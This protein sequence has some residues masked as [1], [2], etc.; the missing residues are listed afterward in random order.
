MSSVLSSRT[1]RNMALQ[2]EVWPSST[3]A[4]EEWSLPM[5]MRKVISLIGALVIAIYSCGSAIAAEEI[6]VPVPPLLERPQV[7]PSSPE[8]QTFAVCGVGIKCECDN[9]VSIAQARE[10]QSC[11]VTSSTG[12]CTFQSREDDVGVCCVCRP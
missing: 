10:G 9:I 8:V 7:L 5:H 4:L 6:P 1:R 11:T 3:L 2:G 12:S